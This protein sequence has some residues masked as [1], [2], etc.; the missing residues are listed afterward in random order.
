MKGVPGISPST[1]EILAVNR[2]TNV[3]GQYFK[4]L[5]NYILSVGPFIWNA[6]TCKPQ[7]TS[8]NTPCQ[9]IES[10]FPCR[11]DTPLGSP[12]CRPR[13]YVGW[14]SKVKGDPEK[15]LSYCTRYTEQ[16]FC[17]FQSLCTVRASTQIAQ[18]DDS[19][20]STAIAQVTEVLPEFLLVQP[21][22]DSVFVCMCT[23]VCQMCVYAV[24]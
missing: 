14:W 16:S 8:R 9:R 4:L 19:S 10:S 12:M 17:T 18:V 1:S 21:L 5:P 20:G 24:T 22:L 11:G 2:S 7:C 15:F 6:N 23:Y 3:S 13:W